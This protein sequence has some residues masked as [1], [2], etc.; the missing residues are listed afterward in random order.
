MNY[1]ILSAEELDPLKDDFI[2]FLSA[3]TITGEDWAKIKAEKPEEAEK[4]IGI[5]SDIVWERS[6]EKIKCLEHRDEKYL[7]VFLCGEEK[8]NMVGFSVNAEN[9]PSLLTEETF[10]KLGTGELRFSEL[11]AEFYTSEKD[12]KD[13][14]ATEMFKMIEAGCTPCEEAYYYGIKSL[15]K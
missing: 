7:K 13:N 8:M 12:Y 2:K 4:I 1:R 11:N 15:I 9:A 6:L 14:R 10:T 5:F 3:N